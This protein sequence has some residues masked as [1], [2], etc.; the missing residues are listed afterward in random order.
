[1]IAKGLDFPN[2]TLVGV[3]SADTSLNLPDF[4]ASERTF[5]LISQVA[6][7]SGRGATPGEVVIQTFDPENY[8]IKCA[9][10]HDYVGFLRAGAGDA[11]GAVAIRRLRRW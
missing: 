2:V 10:E 8:A 1:M 7:R 11:A 5:Q 6:G 3:I 4:R 9:V